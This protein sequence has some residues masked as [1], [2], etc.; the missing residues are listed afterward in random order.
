MARTFNGSNQRLTL[1]KAYLSSYSGAFTISAWVKPASLSGSAKAIVTSGIG[2]NYWHVDF[3]NTADSVGF[4]VNNYTGTDPKTSSGIALT[5]TDITNGAFVGFRYQGAGAEWSKWKNGTKTLINAAI[6]F[7]FP[8][9]SAASFEI[10]AVNGAFF[11]EG[12]V[13]EVAIWNV[14][15]SDAQMA[16][17]GAGVAPDCVGGTGGLLGYWPLRGNSSPERNYIIAADTLTL[18]N[19][20]T[21]STH[22]VIVPPRLADTAHAAWVVDLYHADGTVRVATSDL[23]TDVDYDTLG[24][25]YSGKL[26]NDIT[27]SDTTSDI[28]SGILLP[29]DTV[30]TLNNRA[31]EVTGTRPVDL[32]KE[33]R[34]VRVRIR[35]YDRST[36]ALR[37]EFTGLIDD[38]S[39]IS[40]DDVVLHCSS[41]DDA[42]LQQFLP[43]QVI[44]PATATGVVDDE[45]ATTQREDV[46]APIPIVMGTGGIVLPPMFNETDAGSTH[47]LGWGTSVRVGHVWYDADSAA[48]GLEAALA[49]RAGPGTPTS[50]TTTKFT[51]TGDQSRIYTAG[52]P[53]RQSSDSGATW[54]LSTVAS[55][56]GGTVTVDDAILPASPTSIGS[57]QIGGE[58]SVEYGRYK[59]VGSS[60]TFLTTML[61]PAAPT[62]PIL[63]EV[64]DTTRTNPADCIKFLLE[65]ADIGLG[66][67][68]DSSAFTQAA[69]DFTNA[70][71]SSAV[72]GVL[73]GD[74]TQRQ[75]IDV[76]TELCALRGA[77]VWRDADTN[78]WTIQVDTEP[79]AASMTLEFGETLKNDIAEVLSVS[80]TPLSQAVSTLTLRYGANGA[81]QRGN[82]SFVVQDY[83][84]QARMTVLAIGA[85]RVVNS[86]F[87]RDHTTAKR[88][89]YY[90]GKRIARADQRI[91]FRMKRG[92]RRVR[93]GEVYNFTIPSAGMSSVAMRIVG[94]QRTLNDFTF[95]AVGTYNADI[96]TTD[97][98]TINSAVSAPSTTVEPTE[99]TKSRGVGT[100]LALNA[101]FSAGLIKASIDARSIPNWFIWVPINIDA[102]TI[103]NDTQ[104]RGRYYL[105]LQT[106][107][108]AT[109]FL[110]N[111]DA[112][113]GSTTSIAVTEGRRY[114]IS[115]YVDT[116]AAGGDTDGWAFLVWWID[117]S[118]AF[119]SDTEVS[120]IFVVPGDTNSLGWLR[121]FAVVT[122]PT[123]TGIKRAA[124][125]FDFFRES[126]TFKIDAFKFED[127]AG[128]LGRPGDWSRNPTYGIQPAAMG[129][130]AQYVRVSD[131]PEAGAQMVMTTGTAWT[132]GGV[133]LSGASTILGT[134]G[135]GLL[136][137]VTARVTTAVSGPASWSLALGASGGTTTLASG[138]ANS[139]DTTVG[140]ADMLTMPIFLNSATPIIALAGTATFSAGKVKVMANVEKNVPP[141]S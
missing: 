20:P 71:L 18:V 96:F 48:P 45:E 66:L 78:S 53:V 129:T 6:T 26:T 77:L 92:G 117:S 32:T 30:I 14:A 73:G 132:S 34:Q 131:E 88:V 21:Q 135:P 23:P 37:T 109:P 95:T 40:G 127:V 64:S 10:A 72:K 58:F 70:G 43:R 113:L 110:F 46:G 133:T 118:G 82:K 61:F 106:G 16:E 141:T 87:I 8:A 29:A 136:K 35:E 76:I 115:A 101:D 104:A 15:L 91:V 100:N 81:R 54:N 17:L 93:R 69:T 44:E 107:I 33:W 90:M 11:F 28:D 98:S 36:H 111:Y 126:T 50:S 99:R 86:Q 38:V 105:T 4:W 119:V 55:Y 139:V 79:T 12:A 102:L 80:K 52:M 1:S 56:A 125:G 31:H 62:S 85:A 108:G 121:Y 74:R 122:V 140:D 97:I 3:E 116:D 47:L 84:Y 89:L 137:G 75:A 94:R 134:A 124:P 42:I 60:T 51:V 68:V 130:G 41:L 13:A 83:L 138:L 9:L 112:D 59:F 65:N 7:G 114:Y 128:S 19:A 120:Q 103:T 67:T 39:D 49:F 24:A 63:A 22:P 27:I 123:G 57:L 5:S 2:P 25:F